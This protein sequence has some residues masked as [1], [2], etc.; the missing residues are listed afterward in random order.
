MRDNLNFK[1]KGRRLEFCLIILDHDLIILGLQHQHHRPFQVQKGLVVM[2]ILQVAKRKHRHRPQRKHRH[3]PQP[4]QAHLH[5]T[6][7]WGI[8]RRK[9][10]HRPQRKHRHRPQPLQAGE[11][12]RQSPQNGSKKRKMWRWHKKGAS[13]DI[14]VKNK[15]EK[16]AVRRCFS[17]TDL[18]KGPCSP[19][20]QGNDRVIHLSRIS[21]IGSGGMLMNGSMLLPQWCRPLR[22]NKVPPPNE[23]VHAESKRLLKIGP[24]RA[25]IGRQIKA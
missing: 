6:Q 18:L 17:K 2:T 10:R 9:H 23:N 1:E 21:R 12:H 15:R 7:R 25:K 16:R 14:I 8:H 3:R 4:L 24:L 5:L 22:L 19:Q 13:A 20:G 11:H